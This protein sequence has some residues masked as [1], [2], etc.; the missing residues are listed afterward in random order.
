[1]RVRRWLGAG[2]AMVGVTGFVGLRVPPRPLPDL[3]LPPLTTTPATVPLPDGLPGPVERFYRTRYG[4]ELPVVASAVITGRG[5]MRVNGLTLPVRWRFSHDTG[6][7]YRHHIEVTFLGRTVLR[8]HETYLDGRARLELPFG[9]SEGRKVD[10]GANLGRWAEMVWMPSVWLT[11]PRVRWE[12]VDEHTALLVVPG[13]DGGEETFVARFHATGEL[14]RLESDR[15]PGEHAPTRTRWI[16]E[17]MVWDELDGEP[18][19]VT[20]TLTWE[21]D[22]RPWARLTTEQVVVNVEVTDHLRAT[23]P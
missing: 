10:Q 5:T 8:V 19:P 12:P 20:T 13:H 22:G 9:V 4:D 17:V 2:L 6:R 23:G 16:N 21:D 14:H 11:D 18:Q 3:A 7:G 15:Y 1:M